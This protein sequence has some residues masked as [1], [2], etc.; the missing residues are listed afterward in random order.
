MKA[1]DFHLEKIWRSNI[2]SVNF[3]KVFSCGFLLQTLLDPLTA[4]KL[5]VLLLLIA[6]S[7]FFD[8]AQECRK[9]YGAQNFPP[10]RIR[11]TTA[12]VLESRR[13]GLEHY[14]QEI[15]L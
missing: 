7:Y 5:N 11:N 8:A 13:A 6:F 10:K 2:I 15:I 14:I 12:R 4:L 9:Y 1:V 3:H